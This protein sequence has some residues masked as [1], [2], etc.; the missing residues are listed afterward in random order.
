MTVNANRW[1][2]AATVSAIAIIALAILNSVPFDDFG[3]NGPHVEFGWPKSY[4]V[5]EPF[6][7]LALGIDEV[8]DRWDMTAL[9]FDVG[10]GVTVTLAIAFVAWY[11]LR[12]KEVT[13]ADAQ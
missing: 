6:R 9:D 12:P 2:A 11:I 1:V 10:A 5:R 7:D 3:P 8:R 13:E 4:C